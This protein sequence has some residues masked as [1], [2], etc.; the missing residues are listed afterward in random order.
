MKQSYSLAIIGPKDAILGFKA[1]GVDAVNALN[2]T[3]AL[4][5]INTLVKER[6]YDTDDSDGRAKYAIIFI[7]EELAKEIP[8]DEYKKISELMIPAV[9]PI[10]SHKG[11]EGYGLV[12]IKSFIERA[13]GSDILG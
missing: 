12:R 6:V 13:V 5:A 11:T 10:P 2:A 9:V 8:E 3:E 1:L 4:E 7:M